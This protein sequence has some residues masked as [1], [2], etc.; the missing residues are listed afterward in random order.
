MAEGQAM[1]VDAAMRWGPERFAGRWVLRRTI[2]DRR[3][4]PDGRFEGQALLRP[5][6]LPAPSSAEAA[7]AAPGPGEGSGTEVLRYE[8]EGTLWLGNAAPMRA[9]RG[10]VWR[11][12]GDGV[13][14]LFP[15]GRPFHAFRPGLDGAGTDHPCGP[16]LYRVRYGFG[17]G[18]WWSEWQVTGPR[19][20]YVMRTDYA[21][22]PGGAGPACS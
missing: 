19:K 3:G 5:A 17:A 10:Y 7:G 15:D 2:R 21:R 20:D 6:E 12:A 22:P 4:G 1:A 8:E 18:G 16:D 13:E 11:F 9:T 14:V